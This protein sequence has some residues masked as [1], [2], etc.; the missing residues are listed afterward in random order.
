MFLDKTRIASFAASV[1]IML[2]VIEFNGDCELITGAGNASDISEI[3][4]ALLKCQEAQCID[5]MC[6][7]AQHE[8]VIERVIGI[9]YNI[10]E[11][12]GTLLISIFTHQPDCERMEDYGITVQ[13]LLSTMRLRGNFQAKVYHDYSKSDL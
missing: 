3:V 4:S 5:N 2:K 9:F 7:Y 1:K 10:V 11:K 8:Q 6:R 12:T 13:I